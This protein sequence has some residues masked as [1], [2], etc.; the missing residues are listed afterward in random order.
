MTGTTELFQRILEKLISQGVTDSI[1]SSHWP[2]PESGEA[3]YHSLIEEGVSAADIATAFSQLSNKPIYSIDDG[4]FDHEGAGWGIANNTLYIVNPYGHTIEE[5]LEEQ[6][7]GKVNFSKTGILIGTS[8]ITLTQATSKTELD[9]SINEMIESALEV[10]AS[11]IHV[12]PRT[13]KHLSI[14]FRSDGV[15]KPY[16]HKISMD[17][18]QDWSNKLL[19]RAGKIGGKPTK[20]L[21]LKFNYLWKDKDIQVRLA[22]S[23]VMSGGDPYFYFVMRLLNPTGQQRQLKDIGFPKVEYET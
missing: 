20:P 10:G 2:I 13:R 19:G 8:T 12:S 1:K 16:Q 11:D 7:K 22:A 9:K 21:D 15:I 5:M 18:Y 17:E 6:A 23:P 3:I 14:Q 4:E